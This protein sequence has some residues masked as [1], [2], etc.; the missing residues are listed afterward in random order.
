MR[1]FWVFLNYFFF[2]LKT[3]FLKKDLFILMEIF[4]V[5]CESIKLNKQ[6]KIIIKCKFKMAEK[7]LVPG[8]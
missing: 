6:P 2:L 4:R 7:W 8:P 1:T 3:V 5:N